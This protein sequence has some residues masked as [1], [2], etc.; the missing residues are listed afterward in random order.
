MTALVVLGAVVAYLVVGAA[1][2]RGVNAVM[3]PDGG[4]DGLLY[5]IAIWPLAL[6]LALVVGLVYAVWRIAGGRP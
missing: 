2:V 6:L 1:V 3:D 5:M 4:D